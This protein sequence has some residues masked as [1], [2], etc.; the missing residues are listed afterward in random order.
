MEGRSGILG[1]TDR[2]SA[3]TVDPGKFTRDDGEGSLTHQQVAMNGC[4]RL[5]RGLR[6]SVDVKPSVERYMPVKS[7]DRESLLCGQDRLSE[8]SRDRV[9]G[10]LSIL[11]YSAAVV[12][13]PIGIVYSGQLGFPFTLRTLRLE[14]FTTDTGGS[15]RLSQFLLPLDTKV[16]RG[17]L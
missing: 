8:L 9:I 17:E 1:P 13:S 5:C 2:Y 7:R 16:S 3:R 11:S 15:L 6:G 4:D 12:G 10:E 14:R